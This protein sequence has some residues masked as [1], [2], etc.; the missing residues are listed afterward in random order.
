MASALTPPRLL[1]WRPDLQRRDLQLG[2]EIRTSARHFC[3]VGRDGLVQH[4][5][6]VLTEPA[7]DGV[8]GN[9]RRGLL[10]LSRGSA[11]AAVRRFGQGK[12]KVSH[13]CRYAMSP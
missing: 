8:P 5:L 11:E 4:R 9:G 13:R 2:I 12:M 3:G 6:A 7:L 1:R 10:R